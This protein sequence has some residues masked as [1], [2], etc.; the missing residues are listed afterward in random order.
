MPATVIIFRHHF[1]LEPPIS[2]V[3]LMKNRILSAAPRSI[4]ILS[5][6]QYGY[7][8]R[9]GGIDGRFTFD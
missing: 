1:N 6:D 7:I 2:L 5:E 9:N 4:N 8:K 3:V